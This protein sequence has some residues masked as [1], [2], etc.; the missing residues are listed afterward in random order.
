MRI[1]WV[2]ISFSLSTIPFL[3]ELSSL[4]FNTK[5]TQQIIINCMKECL[6]KSTKRTKQNILNKNKYQ[7]HTITDLFWKKKSTKLILIKQSPHNQNQ[8][9]ITNYHR[10][11]ALV[12]ERLT[13]CNCENANMATRERKWST[14]TREM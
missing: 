12:S 6:K 13:L 5:R 14:T 8:I 11:Q 7:I 10:A 2:F 4:N 1:Q 9:S 3:L